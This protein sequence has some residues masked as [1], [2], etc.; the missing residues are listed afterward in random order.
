MLHKTIKLDVSGSENAFLTTYIIEENPEMPKRERPIVLICPGGAYMSVSHREGEPVALRF[1]A[2]GY[3]AAV[4]NYSV[5]P[6]ATY[7]RALLELGTAVG[8]LREHAKEWLIDKDRIILVGFSAGGHLAASYGCFWSNEVAGLLGCDEEILKPNGLILGYPVITSGKYASRYSFV[9]LLGE[10]YDEL[11]EKMSLEY[12]VNSKNPPTF[13]WHTESDEA[14]PC[15]N[16]RLFAAALEDAGIPVELHVYPEGK[17]GL[18]LA[19]EAT[20]ADAS[21]IVPSC[22]DWIDRAFSWINKTV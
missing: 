2:Q 19:N 22:Q 9:N 8:F 10:K 21:Q 7:P 1:A 14:V 12:C 15:E 13:I 3:H 4:L 17:H 18:A 11:I 5:Y 6:F 16:S 20:A